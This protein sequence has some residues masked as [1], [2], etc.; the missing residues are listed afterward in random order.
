MLPSMPTNRLQKQIDISRRRFAEST[1]VLESKPLSLDMFPMFDQ[2]YNVEYPLL[3]LKCGRQVGKTVTEHNLCFIES[4]A[5]PGFRT[6]YVSPS[7]EQ[8]RRFS[9]SKLGK[10]LH[11]SPDLKGLLLSGNWTCNVTH[12]LYG[13]GSELF[14]SYAGDDGDRIRGISCDRIL[15]DEIQDI[16]YEGVIPIVNECISKSKYKYITYAG[17]PKTLDNTIELLWQRSTQNEWCIQCHSCNHWNYYVTLKGLGKKGIICM[18]CGRYVNPARG[19]WIP[20]APKNKLHGFHIPQIILPENNPITARDKKEYDEFLN[21]WERILLK[22]ETGEYSETVFLNEVIGV[23]TAGG[24]KLLSL[25]ELEAM[26]NPEKHNIRDPGTEWNPRKYRTI[27]AGIDWGGNAKEEQSRT[28]L[29]IFG[30]SYIGQMELLH[31]RIFP[32]ENPVNTQE[33]ILQTLRR[34]GVNLVVCDA[35]EGSLANAYLRKDLGHQRVI[36]VRYVSQKEMMVWDEVLHQGCYKVNRTGMIDNFAL[37]LKNNGGKN[38]VYPRKEECQA[39]FADMLNVFEDVTRSGNKVW[40]K[41]SKMTDD[42]LHSQ[43]YAFMAM[44]IITGDLTWYTDT[45]QADR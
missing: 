6:L 37:H 40:A 35:G 39:L 26:C 4:V 3:L 22:I 11:A 31:F 16:P 33:T 38:V 23:S 12:H 24:A 32:I 14:M 29:T 17:T 13:N 43:V 1:I 8:T 30:L 28:V 42:A 15:Y 36:P 20:H 2:I 44:K 34:F 25:T 18:K 27:V 45:M 41:H 7:Q 10:T 19:M 21:N 5:I 9:K